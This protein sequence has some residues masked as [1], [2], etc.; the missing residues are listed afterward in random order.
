MKA[1]DKDYDTPIT[2]KSYG[3]GRGNVAMDAARTARRLGAQVTV[4]YRRSEAEPC[5]N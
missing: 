1:F 3:C 4:V 5:Q 2:G